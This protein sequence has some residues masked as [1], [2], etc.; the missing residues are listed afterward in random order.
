MKRF[1]FLFLML[2][3]VAYCQDIS[4]S[5]SLNYPQKMAWFKDARLGIFIHWGIYAVNGIAESW[6]FFN[7]YISHDDYVKQTGGFTAKKYDP[8]YWAG[9]IRESGAKY[10]VITTK[11]HDGFALWDTRFGQFNAVDQ[12]PAQKDLIQPFVKALKE[13][14]LKTGFYF[15][16]PDWS[17]KDYTHFTNQKMRYQIADD[18]ERW[19]RFVTYYTGQLKEL[20]SRFDP[21]LW[22]FDGDWEH[23][24]EEWR[25]PQIRSFL[26]EG[27]PDVIFN[28]R[29]QGHGDYETPEIGMP[30]HR[31]SAD[32]WELCMTMNDSWGYQP[33]DR[34]YKSPLQVIDIFVDCISKGG[35]LLL[36]IGPKADGTIPEEQIHIL[37]E[38]GKWTSKHADAVYPVVAGIPYEYFQ[39]PSALSKDSTTLYLYVRDIP[40]DGKV[41]LKGIDNPVNRIYVVGNGTVLHEEVLCKVFWSQYPGIMYI[42]IPEEVLDPYYTVIAIQLDGKIS[43]HDKRSGVIE[44]N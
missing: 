11:H 42:D 43:L 9:L 6:S 12:S 39:G 24:A 26:S 37:K 44:Q 35:N 23:S 14:D 29:L 20:K 8:E 13:N 2:P 30:I 33:N 10:A 27:K 21:D 19:E 4:R 3:G 7:G 5:D 1:L 38:L 18:P 41:V 40:K 25:V 34:N 15:S 31:P 28:S 36:D 22:W 17:Y 16:L 32:Y